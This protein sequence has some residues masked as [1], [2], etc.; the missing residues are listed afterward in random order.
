QVCAEFLPDAARGRG[1]LCPRAGGSFWGAGTGESRRKPRKAAACRLAHRVQRG[2]GHRRDAIA[3]RARAAQRNPHTM[4]DSP[5]TSLHLL[6]RLILAA[7][8]LATAC[9]SS[10]PAAPPTGTA[11]QE[12]VYLVRQHT[13][14]D[15]DGQV[16]VHVTDGMGQVMD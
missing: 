13:T 2:L 5:R 10:E 4:L 16:R 3:S 9:S 6:P 7:L 14:T 12:I 11:F 15:A 8:P 1:G